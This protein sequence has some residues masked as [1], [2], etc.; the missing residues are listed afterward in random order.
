MKGEIREFVD[1]DFLESANKKFEMLGK[2]DIDSLTNLF[3]LG[4]EGSGRMTRVRIMLS[5]IFRLCDSFIKA[6]INS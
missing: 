3:I 4:R 5:K 6:S 2:V 1:L